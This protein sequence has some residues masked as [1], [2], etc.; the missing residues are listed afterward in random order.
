MKQLDKILTVED[1]AKY[2]NISGG[3]SDKY[4]PIYTTDLINMLAPEFKF[5]HGEQVL[6][7]SNAHYVDLVNDEGDRIRILN[8]FDRS[9]ALR[10]SLV[11]EGVLIPLG[12]E[13]LVH[14]GTKAKGFTDEVAESRQ[15]IFEAVAVAK[16]FEM[17]LK[18]TP[19][20]EDVAKDI[21]REIFTHGKDAKKITEIVN[22]VD[23]IDGLDIQRYIN[24]SIRGFLTGNYTY[25]KDAVKAVGKKKNSVLGR[26]Q[27]ENRIVAL[28]TAKYPE[29]FL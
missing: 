11:S 7:R 13:R 24:L 28:F 17:F 27:I 18:N 26:I 10:I 15:E 8:S 21:S 2:E 19:I 9:L 6:G 3:A 1:V 16:K 25:M 20:T 4:V 12:V 23:L 5:D 29:Y 22:Y 14:I